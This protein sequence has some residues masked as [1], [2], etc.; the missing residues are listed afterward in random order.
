MKTLF[1]LQS[2]LLICA[3]TAFA[4]ASG[5]T[6]MKWEKH[7]HDFGTITK[8]H[9]VSTTFEFANEG[10]KPIVIQ[11]VKGSC[12]CTATS[13]EQEPIL[14]GASSEIKATYNAKSVGPFTKTVSVY[15]NQDEEPFILTITGTVAAD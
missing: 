5:P 12:G 3:F 10:D 6:A 11:K 9:P 15:T 4:F 13:Y 1:S 14:P 2:L 8:D 7:K